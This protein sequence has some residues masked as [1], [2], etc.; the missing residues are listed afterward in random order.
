MCAV[1]E[2]HYIHIFLAI[3][4]MGKFNF[5]FHPRTQI[6]RNRPCIALIH[7]FKL[8]HMCAHIHVCTHTRTYICMHGHHTYI[9]MHTHTLI[10]TYTVRHSNIILLFNKR[11]LSNASYQMGRTHSLCHHWRPLSA[12]SSDKVPEYSENTLELP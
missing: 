10:H 8:T 5:F 6:Q 11:E 2:Q 7:T 12:Q 3:R 4:P 1:T 9:Y